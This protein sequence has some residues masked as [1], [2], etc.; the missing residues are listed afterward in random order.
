MKLCRDVFHSKPQSHHHCCC[1]Q[2][3]LTERTARVGSCMC[4][5]ST[6]QLIVEFIFFMWLLVSHP[7]I[8]Q[9][10]PCLRYIL[11]FHLSRTNPVCMCE[12]HS[13][14]PGL[15]LFTTSPSHEWFIKSCITIMTH[16]L[17]HF[18]G[19]KIK[20]CG[21]MA[22]ISEQSQYFRGD[23]FFALWIMSSAR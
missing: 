15:C 7:S 18:S 4:K 13:R 16:G 22:G 2:T 3:A 23:F 5:Y 14:P 20:R 6:P 9:P 10:Y 19:R 1:N 8:S 21:Q 12:S 11:L 17:S